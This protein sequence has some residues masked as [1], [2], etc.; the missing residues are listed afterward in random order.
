VLSTRTQDPVTSAAARRLFRRAGNAAGLAELPA[1]TVER[2]IYPV[3]FYRTKARAL[4]RL[5]RLLL[6]H[7]QGRVPRTAPE[8]LRLPG[9]G[10]KVANIVLSQGFGIPAIAVDTHVLRISNRLG[11]VRTRTPEQTELALTRVLP[12]RFH[13]GWNRLLVALGQTICRPQRP[14]CPVCP[15]RRFCARRGVTRTR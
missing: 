11:L 3:G 7:W 15:V 4:P 10:R 6:E 5:A 12:V 13:A 14:D 1:P 2:L 9:V 8:L